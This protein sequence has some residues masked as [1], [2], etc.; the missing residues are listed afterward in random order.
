MFGGTF[1][2]FISSI[3]KHI[4]GATFSSSCSHI[5]FLSFP[6]TE[7]KTVVAHQTIVGEKPVRTSI[8]RLDGDLN[9]NNPR[10]VEQHSADRR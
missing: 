10:Q 4:E 6:H 8:A 1:G 7:S 9:D 2:A 5:I 3:Y